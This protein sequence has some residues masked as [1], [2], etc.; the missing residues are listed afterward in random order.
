MAMFDER[1]WAAL[2]E[3]KD[4]PLCGPAERLVVAA[5][6]SGRVELVDDG[7]F[8][9]Y[10]ILVFH[11]H[12][13]ELYDLSPDERRAFFDDVARVAQAIRAVCAPAK[14]NYEMLGNVVPHLHCH[15]VARTPDD[16][17]WGRP[18][19]ERPPT[20]RTALDRG[21]YE[22]LAARLRAALDEVP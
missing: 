8:V 19:W 2:I 10:C 11:R 7:D 1:A 9:G 22:A 15:I 14:F 20:E 21:E 16:G 3:G 18:L 12:A 6:P 17:Y 4:C 5:L 13:V